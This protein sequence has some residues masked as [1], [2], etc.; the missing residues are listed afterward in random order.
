MRGIVAVMGALL[1]RIGFQRWRTQDEREQAFRDA[2]EKHRESTDE[3]FQDFRKEFMDHL[4]RLRSSTETSLQT[5]NTT[6]AQVA[7]TAGEIRARMAERYATKDDL[8]AL[9][10][11]VRERFE[12][13]RR[14]CSARD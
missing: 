6:M 9:E 1:V 11:R 10:E 7:Q 12:E 14:S 2:L 13:C 4:D 8:A 5:L 3:A